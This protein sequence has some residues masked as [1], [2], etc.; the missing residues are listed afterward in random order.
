MVPLN[1]LIYWAVLIK[2]GDKSIA[3]SLSQSVRE[4]LYIPIS[5]DIKYRAKV[6]IDMFVNKFAKGLGALLILL[7]FSVLHFTI[8]QMSFIAILFIMVWV[9]LIVLV[10]REYVGIV[11]RKLKIK[12]PD[13]DKIIMEKIDVDMTKLVFDTIQ[14]KRRSSV[15]YA[16]NLFDLIKRKNIVKDKRPAGEQPGQHERRVLEDAGQGQSAKRRVG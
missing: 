11:K 14:S 4:L 1:Y 12:W 15:L 7:F 3:H 8:K 9:T 16:M 6:F 10:N 13:A 5:P 2:G